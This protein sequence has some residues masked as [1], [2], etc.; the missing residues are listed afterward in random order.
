M[1]QRK[2]QFSHETLREEDFAFG[3]RRIQA[4]FAAGCIPGSRKCR[5]FV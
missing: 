3:T 5:C 1:L 4:H 2:K